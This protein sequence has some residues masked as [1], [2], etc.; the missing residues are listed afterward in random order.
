MS[1]CPVVSL[2]T[3][4]TSPELS[5]IVAL[6]CFQVTRAFCFRFRLVSFK[7]DVDKVSDV[8]PY[9]D[10]ECTFAASIRACW[11]RCR[12]RATWRSVFWA[13]CRSCS[14]PARS[15]PQPPPP[16]ASRPTL[17]RRSTANSG[18]SIRR[19]A[20]APPAP[21]CI[22]AFSFAPFLRT[23]SRGDASLLVKHLFCCSTTRTLLSD[24]PRYV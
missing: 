18:A 2:L 5:F 13:P 12:R 8:V 9:S 10:S 11:R 1:P 16:P 4:R 15:R 3:Q 14:T 22:C 19:S 23:N 6:P 21:V 24:A 20:R 17:A 7:Y